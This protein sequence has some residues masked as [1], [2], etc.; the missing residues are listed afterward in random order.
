M[1]VVLS[2]RTGKA[3]EFKDI[4]R[5]D[6]SGS[7]QIAESSV[8]VT[9]NRDTPPDWYKLKFRGDRLLKAAAYL[10]KGVLVS[11]VGMLAFE[12]WTDDQGNRKSRPVVTVTEIQLPPKSEA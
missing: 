2:G 10:G 12:D 4:E 7:F 6:G 8:A 5:K 3:I 9:V 11:I 1:Q